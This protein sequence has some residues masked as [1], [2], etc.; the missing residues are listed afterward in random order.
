VIDRVLQR[1]YV[2]ARMEAIS[3]SEA[4]RPKSPLPADIDPEDPELPE[5]VRGPLTPEELAAADEAL[6]LTAER[7]R[8]VPIGPAPDLGRG[9]LGRPLEERSYFPHDP[10]TS[11]AQSALEA[12]L[13]ARRGDL[14]RPAAGAAGNRRGGERPDPVATDILDIALPSPQEDRRLGGPFEI[15]DIGWAK[16]AIAMG[17][18]LARRRRPFVDRPSDPVGL[19]ANARVIVVGDWASGHHRAREVSRYMRQQI[20]KAGARKVHVIHLGDTYYGGWKHEYRKNF[21]PHWP[22]ASNEAHGSWSLNGNH[23]MNTGGWAYFD[24]LLKDSRFAAQQQSSVFSLEGEEWQILGL[25]TAWKDHGLEGGQAEWVAKKLRDNGSR[26]TILMSH[27]QLFS[28][29]GSQGPDVEE[30]LRRAGALK[31]PIDAWFWGHEHRCVVYEPDAR[32]R[33]A[34]LVGHGGVPVYH[35]AA[36]KPGIRWREDQFFKGGFLGR[37]KWALFGFAVLDFNGPT[38]DVTYFDEW[39]RDR[40]RETLT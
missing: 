11:I 38:V 36:V 27:H 3:E 13:Y 25:D 9:A 17:L 31:T 6:R 15:T 2:L 39:G 37:E 28:A 40:F 34:R 5:E 29:Y 18:R 35:D 1:S 4:A 33:Q 8:R 10:T 30:P 16:S 19:D 14:L 26:K 22:V 23:D 20:E 12:Y 32:V 21:L 24:Y 7:E